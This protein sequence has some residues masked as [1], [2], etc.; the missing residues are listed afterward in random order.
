MDADHR[1]EL[2]RNE[3]AEALSQLRD[4][5]DIDRRYL[6]AVGVLLVLLLAV[7]AYRVTSS[8]AASAEARNWAQYASIAVM[9]GPDGLIPVAELREA[10]TG[11]YGPAVANVAAVRLAAALL[12]NAATDATNRTALINE[13]MTTLTTRMDQFAAL[14]TPTLEAAA[15]GLLARAY[16]AQGELDKARATYELLNA[17]RFK[18][19]PFSTPI[20][21]GTGFEQ[22]ALAVQ[23]LENLNE[24]RTPVVMLPGTSAPAVPPLP[25]I[26]PATAP[27]AP[28]AAAT[29]SAATPD[30]V[31]TPTE[32]A[33]A[34]TAESAPDAA[35][36]STDAAGTDD[37]PA[38][39]GE[40]DPN[41]P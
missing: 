6:L 39:A 7:I 23:R 18:G 17:E 12:D 8:Y 21:V 5:Q 33:P 19:T 9:P 27:A 37:A 3:L 34:E 22:D 38:P 11:G 31:E 35:E 30:D 28:P 2:K 40:D 1:H 26:P 36:E 25:D 16:E 13:A 29:E 41:Q 10:A 15:L 20:G 14:P 32:D 4:W 24:L